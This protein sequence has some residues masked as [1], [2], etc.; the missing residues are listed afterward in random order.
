MSII[1]GIEGEGNQALINKILRRNVPLVKTQHN[2]SVICHKK[3]FPHLIYVNNIAYVFIAIN[4]NTPVSVHIHL[5]TT[6]SEHIHLMNGKSSETSIHCDM[7]VTRDTYSSE[8]DSIIQKYIVFRDNL[9]YNI[10]TSD[11]T[12][13]ISNAYQIWIIT[14]PS[15]I[16][17]LFDFCMKLPETFENDKFIHDYYASIH[18]RYYIPYINLYTNTVHPTRLA[19]LGDTPRIMNAYH[20]LIKHVPTNCYKWIGMQKVE[21]TDN[22]DICSIAGRSMLYKTQLYDSKQLEVLLN[23]RLQKAAADLW[24]EIYVNM[25]DKKIMKIMLNNFKNKRSLFYP[26]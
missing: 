24:R 4:D 6:Q 7:W 10:I 11:P 9:E 14:T 23:K 16:V 20:Y 19:Y 26:Y 25:S 22:S 1:V 3:K 21:Y 2:L 5:Y 12:K 13:Y 17:K 8:F 15:V 18:P